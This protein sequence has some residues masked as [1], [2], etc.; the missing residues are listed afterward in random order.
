MS[1]LSWMGRSLGLSTPYNRFWSTYFGRETHAGET[2]NVSSALSLSGFWRGIRLY[3][4]TVGSLPLGIFETDAAGNSIAI[5]DPSNPYVALFMSPNEYQTGSEFWESL[6]AAELVLGNGYAL[7]RRVGKRLVA[8]DSVDQ[9][10]TAPYREP[11]SNELRYRGVDLQNNSFDVPASEMFHLKGFS[12]G[13]DAGV[14]CIYYAAQS[15]GVAQA[16]QKTAGKMFGSGL[17][18]S[19]FVQ[20]NSILK[21]GDREKFEG[22][23][24]KYQGSD[25]AGKMMILEAGTTFN[26]ITMKPVDAEL[27]ATMGFSVE[28]IGRWL[29]MPPILLG[30]S[31]AGQTNWGTG[32][33][34]IIG[35]WYTLGLRAKLTRTEKAI[36]K[37]L[38]D[39]GDRFKFFPKFNVDGLLRGDSASQ[40]ALFSAAAQN[41]WLTRNEIRKLLD[42]PPKEGG[43]ELTVQV[44]LTLLKD[45]GSQNKALATQAKNALLQWLN[46][47]ENPAAGRKS[48]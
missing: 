42:L 2:V 12:F 4:E 15:L 37:R 43:D 29:G 14:S 23:L 1:L 33:E 18:A 44:N 30:H 35:A 32:I 26:G 16:A 45:L 39:P 3:A 10:Q 48:A 28:E 11:G 31:S 24:S 9:G 25:A 22:I 40:A 38:F 41:G 17:S 7:K 20:T 34:S 6:I 36:T 13:G 46:D 5:K 19:G 27:L 21:D 8:L 47:N